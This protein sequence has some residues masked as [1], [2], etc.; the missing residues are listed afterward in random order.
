LAGFSAY[1][2]TAL[3]GFSSC[4][5]GFGGGWDSSGAGWGGVVAAGDVLAHLDADLELDLDAGEELKLEVADGL[6]DVL[7]NSFEVVPVGTGLEGVGSVF[8]H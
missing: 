2:D 8:V 6:L 1:G 5:N 7:R 3:A 4:G